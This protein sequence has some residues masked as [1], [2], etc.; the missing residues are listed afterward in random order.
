M[1]QSGNWF[2]YLADGLGSTMAIVDSTGTVQKSYQYE[3][4]GEPTVTGG[5]ANE[6]DFAGQQ[7]DP[8]GL[9]YLR[10]RYYDPVSGTFLSRE[11]LALR[12]GWMGNPFGYAGANPARYLDPTGLDKCGITDRLECARNAGE[13]VISVLGGGVRRAGGS[14]PGAGWAWRKTRELVNRP[15]TELA[16]HIATKPG[17]KCVAYSGGITVCLGM[18]KLFD[19]VG[20]TGHALTIGNT[21][22]VREKDLESW[23]A[24]RP[25]QLAHEIRHADQWS[26]AGLSGALP[27]QVAYALTVAGVSAVLGE[28]WS[29]FEWDAGLASGH[30]RC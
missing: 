21:I 5:L 2:Y 6:F 12:P 28:C 17:G 10:A 24:L 16:R 4:Y 3:V 13:G 26:A 9:Q 22:L 7:T 27:G 19:S 15:W 20:H 1:K 29:P 25:G 14:V 18:G 11:P 30:Y 8:T 23:L